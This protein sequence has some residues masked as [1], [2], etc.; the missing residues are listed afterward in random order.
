MELN[1]KTGI[2]LQNNLTDGAFGVRAHSCVSANAFKLCVAAS[3]A[4]CS[5][6][7]TIGHLT[8]SSYLR[9]SGS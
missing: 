4:A 6:H 7:Q 5:R 2:Q 9:L 3:R 1:S 8:I